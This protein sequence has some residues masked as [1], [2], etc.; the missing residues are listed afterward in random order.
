M[1]FAYTLS[2]DLSLLIY[3]MHQYG[4]N[5]V[6]L[7][8]WRIKDVTNIYTTNINM[9]APASLVLDDEDTANCWITLKDALTECMKLRQTKYILLELSDEEQEFGQQATVIHK[10]LKSDM[11]SEPQ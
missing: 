1:F 3:V 9:F 7:H 6:N 4:I 8:V 2:Q 5:N 11:D 10:T